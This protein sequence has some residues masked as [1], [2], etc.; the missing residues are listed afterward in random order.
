MLQ[1]SRVGK[2]VLLGLLAGV[3]GL[4]SAAPQAAAPE[5]TAEVAKGVVMAYPGD[6]Q[7]VEGAYANA[8][9][10]ITT[11][12]SAK[13]PG[14]V[15]RSQMMITAE[16][17]LSFEDAWRGWNRSRRRSP[18]RRRLFS[19]SR[20]GRRWARCIPR[21]AGV[22]ASNGGIASST[23]GGLTFVNRGGIPVGFPR[24]GD[25]SLAVGASGNFYLGFIAF[26]NG[27]PAALGV[28][29]CSTG[30]DVSANGVAFNFVGH[31]VVC[32]NGVNACFPDQEHIA[33]DRF[34][35][36]ATGDQVYSV[37]RNFR[38]GGTPGSGQ[39]CL[40]GSGFVT[41]SLVCSRNGG[42]AWGAPVAVAGS[43]DFPRVAVG[44]DGFVYVV[45]RQGNNV[46]LN[47]FSSCANGL[48][49]QAGWPVTVAT[50]PGVT[51]PVSGLDRCNDGNTL[52]SQTVAADD[53]AA[54]HVFV[55]YAFNTAARNEDVRV[56]ESVD[57]GRTFPRL[58]RAN[59]AVTGR[60][61]MP[62]L[63][64]TGGAAYVGWYDRRAAARPLPPDPACVADCND[65]L[66]SCLEDLPPR[67]CL[68]ARAVC[69]R[70]CSRSPDND[71]TE[72]FSARVTRSGASLVAAETNLSGRPDAQCASGWPCAP[73]S[74][75]DSES[76]PHPELPQLAGVCCDATMAGCPGSRQR[77]DFST[78][79]CP[80]GET[81]NTGGGCPKYGDYNGS[82]CAAGR[83]FFAWASAT[84]PV[85]A[86]AGAGIRVFHAAT[87]APATL[88]VRKILSPSSD[89]GRFILN[90]DLVG[91]VVVGNQGT[92]GP[93]PVGPGTHVVGEVAAA[94][95]S[96]GSYTTT[97][98]GDCS[99]S[100]SVTLASGDNKTCTI[101][102]RR[103]SRADCLADCAE[104][105]ADC[106]ESTHERGGP[107]PAQCA[108]AFSACRARCPP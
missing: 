91:I 101:T 12:P 76:C 74:M 73:R 70:R 41:P 65:F 28:T 63:C 90:V 16:P 6:W 107:T 56:H 29:G 49:Q 102:N 24:D 80:A 93:L 83:A 71:L 11:E 89:P 69:L 104:F 7:R 88:T 54:N 68:P 99:A 18:R 82:G 64:A 10:L 47:K 23:D 20:A 13:A 87:A 86:P 79:A 66:Q 72:Y 60:R 81:C 30:I 21:Q 9:Q 46:V 55:A 105:R 17:R 77:C 45:I 57:G 59:A 40:I 32:P 96:L 52:A 5:R 67:L 27:T 2:V 100:G 39:S 50:A 43:G 15:L 19:P 92:T 61:F 58:A 8:Q 84:S 78:P 95:T 26:P 33:A 14:E 108:Q 38:P 22:V 94:G 97:I 98:G 44:R 53:L 42:V 3:Y 48:A 1:W 51:C 36:A 4:L 35:A 75:T 34:N 103:E 37:W 25:P 31:A 62:W 85:G 106:F